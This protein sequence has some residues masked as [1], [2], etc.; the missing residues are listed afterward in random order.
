MKFIQIFIPV[1]ILHLVVIAVILLQPGCQVRQTPPPPPEGDPSVPATGNPMVT[2]EY[3]PTPI[4]EPTS[5]PI[6]RQ[7]PMRPV[8]SGGGNALSSDLPS[9]FNANLPLDDNAPLLKPVDE[10]EDGA[11]Y[12]VTEMEPYTIVPGDTLSGIARR[13]GVSIDSLREANALAGD[14]IGAGETLMIPA[15]GDSAGGLGLVGPAMDTN[16]DSSGQ[17]YEVVA[18]DNLTVIARRYGVSVAEIKALNKL[19]SDTIQVGQ[20]L[21]VPE[22]N[23]SYTPPP[24]APRSGP[25]ATNDGTT[26]TVR[27]GDTPITIA[28]RLKVSHKELMRVNGITDPT[29]M[30]VGQVLIVPGVSSAQPTRTTTPPPSRTVA[31]SPPPATVPLRSEPSRPT[32]IDGSA[33]DPAD[34]E[35]QMDDVPVSPVEVVE[36]TGNGG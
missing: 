7:P 2:N 9:A 14:R 13:F 24:P 5:Q 15:A 19:S 22:R 8:G 21:Y 31:P 6:N 1:A 35:A 32:V 25:V 17:A 11:A 10:Y 28:R 26:Y 3:R 30:K 27:P 36:P 29:R 16:L 23:A 33:L 12:A 4:A 20:K 18:G 34:L